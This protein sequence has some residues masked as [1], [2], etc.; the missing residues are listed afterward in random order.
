MSAREP[1][2][3]RIVE[4]Q[5]A[6]YR[7]V[8]EA[9]AIVIAGVW[10]FYTFVYQEK[11]KPAG[12]PASLN[13]SVAIT[14]LGRD[15]RREVLGI[16]V[17]F[18]NTGKTEIDIAADAYNVWGD[19]YGARERST[20]VERHGYHAYASSIPRASRRIVERFAE[21][22]DAAVGGVVGTHIVL[23]PGATETVA[24]VIVVPRGEYDVIHAQVVAVPVKTSD[25]EKVH[26][27]IERRRNGGFWLHTPDAFEDDNDTDF[28]LIP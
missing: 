5:W 13:D 26:V 19:R 2:E 20:S 28:A 27:S 22:R 14:R 23:E 6:S 17:R 3:I 16:A 1:R 9:V 4:D 18:V 24:D 7:H 11:I 8:I 25:P 12:E 21:L 10:A 15:A